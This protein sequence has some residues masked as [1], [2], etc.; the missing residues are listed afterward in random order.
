[1]LEKQDEQVTI[2]RAVEGVLAAAFMTTLAFRLRDERALIDGLRTL[3]N[4][5]EA[6]REATDA[7]DGTTEESADE[8]LATE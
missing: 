3:T 8:A 5:V 4:A 2:S 1:M 7:E 6:Y